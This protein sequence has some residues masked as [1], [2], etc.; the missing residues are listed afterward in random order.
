VRSRA[1]AALAAALLFPLSL[2]ASC[3][4]SSCPL[5][6]NALNKPMAG[7]FALDLSFQYIDQDRLSGH[8]DVAPDHHEVRTINRTASL[9]LAYA[10]SDRL[11]FSITAPYLS[12]FHEHLEEG[13][14]ERFHLHGI[15]DV[16]LQARG[17][18]V[19]HVWLIGG[20]KL[21][22]GSHDADAEVPLLPGTGSTDVIAGVSFESGT[23]RA[24]GAHGPMGNTALVPLF[25]T[26]TYRRN[27]RGTRDY[28][29]GDEVQLNAGTAYPLRKHVE[30]LLQVNARRR[31]RDESA[32]DPGDAFFTGGTFVFA[33]PG[34]RVNR[35]NAAWYALVQLPL[36]QRVNAIQL[37]AKRNWVTGVQLRF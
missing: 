24:T 9:L 18:V 32:E 16:T 15:G 2:Q 22:T 25:A 14:P 27:G 34:V 20:V 26:L 5:D 7:G 6:L 8:S 23:L 28:R 3:G 11:Q 12:R 35:G 17:R 4:S 33:S 13:A 19:P 21:P 36:V 37:T 1:L 29:V 30:L 10:A 31:E